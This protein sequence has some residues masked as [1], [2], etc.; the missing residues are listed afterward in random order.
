[1]TTVCTQILRIW[2]LNNFP[3][4]ETTFEKEKRTFILQMRE[5]NL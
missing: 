5:E 3:A 4:D 1:M 2:W